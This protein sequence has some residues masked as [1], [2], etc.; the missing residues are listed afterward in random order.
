[1]LLCG[2]VVRSEKKTSEELLELKSMFAN[3]KGRPLHNG[4][5]C[6]QCIPQMPAEEVPYQ[7]LQLFWCV[8]QRPPCPPWTG[9]VCA[10]FEIADCGKDQRLLTIP[11]RGHSSLLMSIGVCD[12]FTSAWKTSL[13]KLCLLSLRKPVLTHQQF[14]GPFKNRVQQR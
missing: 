4:R 12:L 8:A 9:L 3:P 11:T 13:Q 7:S 10:A 14:Q 5:T 1:M 2:H 6:V